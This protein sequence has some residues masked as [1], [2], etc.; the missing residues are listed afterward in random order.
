M[1]R[2]WVLCEAGKD[3]LEMLM[4]QHH[5]RD[6]Q[7]V[8]RIVESSDREVAPCLCVGLTLLRDDVWMFFFVMLR[9]EDI[10]LEGS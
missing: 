2:W 6:P 10:R 9:L 5:Q 1:L 4:L 8:E 7:R 3:I